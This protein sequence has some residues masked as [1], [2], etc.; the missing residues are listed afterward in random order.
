MNPL[1]IIAP[2][3]LAIVAVLYG[4]FRTF[5][6][7]WLD[8]R[9]RLTILEKAERNPQVMD[10]MNELL[11]VLSELPGGSGKSRQDYTVTGVVLALLGLAGILLGRFMHVGQFAVGVYV[12]GYVCVGLGI[13]LAFL[14]VFVRWISRTPTPAV[15]R[16]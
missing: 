8:H 15:R 3:L 11:D 5:G 2:L 12:G 7:V 10:S 14:G 16:Q 6:R 4:V 1:F 9:I 13:A